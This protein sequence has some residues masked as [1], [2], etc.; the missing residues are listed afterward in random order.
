M[1]FSCEKFL[2]VCQNSNGLEQNTVFRPI[3]DQNASENAKMTNPSQM[4]SLP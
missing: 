3:F 2:P 1:N 4:I